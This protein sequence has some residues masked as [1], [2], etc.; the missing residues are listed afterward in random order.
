VLGGCLARQKKC[1][2]AEPLL[3][4]GY[5]GLTKAKG[6]PAQRVDEALVRVIDLYETWAK[7]EQAEE[8]RKKQ[9]ASADQPAKLASP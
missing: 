7:P 3:L 8:W 5:E 4:S 2:E 6:T 9:T 1:A